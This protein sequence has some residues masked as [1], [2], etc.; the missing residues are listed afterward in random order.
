MSLLSLDCV[1][2]V[3]TCSTEVNHSIPGLG[4]LQKDVIV[5]YGDALQSQFLMPESSDVDLSFTIDTCSTNS[6]AEST[7]LHTSSKSCDVVLLLPP[8]T[9]STDLHLIQPCTQ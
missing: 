6:L 8:G 4:S 9:C 5:E 7:N 3:S 2:R 1:E